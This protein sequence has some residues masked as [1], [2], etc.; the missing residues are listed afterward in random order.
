MF[1]IEWEHLLPASR[2]KLVTLPPTHQWCLCR[3]VALQLSKVHEESCPKFII[4]NSALFGKGLLHSLQSSWQTSDDGS[5]VPP[6]TKTPSAFFPLTL[7]NL[8]HTVS[9]SPLHSTTSFTPTHP[10]AAWSTLNPAKDYPAVLPVH[11]NMMET[12]KLF[13]LYRTIVLSSHP[14]QVHLECFASP[15]SRITL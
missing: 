11:N 13:M 10:S 1:K 4:E 12:K 2:K 5:P 8:H 9:G 15:G 6:L 3:L 14:A 7:P